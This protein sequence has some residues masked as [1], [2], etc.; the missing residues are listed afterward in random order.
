MHKHIFTEALDFLQ[1]QPPGGMRVLAALTKLSEGQ[2]RA[3]A[4]G[5]EELTE[6]ITRKVLAQKVKDQD[7]EIRT[8][9]QHAADNGKMGIVAMVCGVPE[10]NCWDVLN[11]TGEIP[12]FD[13][14][15]LLSTLN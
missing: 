5:T 7:A 14:I 4:F 9:L 10:S 12:T 8:A 2:L 11:S 15:L 6:E 13:R 3:I 1:N